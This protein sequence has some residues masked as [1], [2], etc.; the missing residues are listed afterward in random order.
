MN[1]AENSRPSWIATF[2][3]SLLLWGGVLS[4]MLAF[5]HILA[6]RLAGH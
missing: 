4:A 6:N 3:L 2:L 5:G 1:S